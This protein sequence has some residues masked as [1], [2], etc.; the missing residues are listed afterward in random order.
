MRKSTA[1]HGADKV[2]VVVFLFFLLG[3][4]PLI[5]RVPH[6]VNMTL[7]EAEMT[8]LTYELGYP[9]QE[10]EYSSTVPAGWIIRQEPEAGEVSED[11]LENGVLVVVSRGPEP[12]ITVPDVVG[13]TLQEARNTLEFNPIEDI[14]VVEEYSA[15]VPMGCVIRQDPEPGQIPASEA[16]DGILLVISLGPDLSEGETFLLPGAV[17]LVMM[18]IPAGSFMMGHYPDE[19]ECILQQMNRKEGAR[20]C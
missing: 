3:C 12:T 20:P 1:F 13:M 9:R 15:T 19:Q 7:E 11:E 14:G 5:M 18:R 10:S 8:L 6:V 16:E 17:P 2:A 4:P